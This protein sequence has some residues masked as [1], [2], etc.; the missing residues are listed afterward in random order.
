MGRPRLI[1]LVRHG[2]SESNCDKSVNRFIANHQIP[3]TELGNQQAR[4]AG[5]DLLQMLRPGENILF[6]T[7]P[8]KRARQTLEGILSVVNQQPE[9]SYRVHEEPRLREQ[10]FGN[11]QGTAREMKEIWTDRAKY[12]H[13]FYRIPNGESAADVYDRCAGFNETLFRQ[14]ASDKFPS[15]LV[16][17]T[18]GIW[19]RV[20]LMKWFRWPYE[21]FELLQNVPHCKFIV[22]EREEDES[23]RYTLKTKLKTW[24]DAQIRYDEISKA[25]A[26]IDMMSEGEFDT[27]DSRVRR[28]MVESATA[29]GALS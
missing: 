9:V 22:M 16:L 3:L 14:F 6:Y 25:C 19:A 27:Q 1:L 28:I 15:V 13:F 21:E 26:R 8:Y 24:S 12:G 11:F 20:F 5:Q 4:E 7:S 10:D 29:K 17:V 18:H 2:E 23:R